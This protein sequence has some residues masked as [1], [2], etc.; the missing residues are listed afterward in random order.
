VHA[1]H[2]IFFELLLVQSFIVAKIIMPVLYEGSE[3]DVYC[4]KYIGIYL[5]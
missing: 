5:W 3:V 1:L 2:N 4:L